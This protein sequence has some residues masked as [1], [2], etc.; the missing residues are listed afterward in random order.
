MA[1]SGITTFLWF[2]GL[3]KE[4]AEFYVSLFPGAEM[5]D[6]SY[7]QRDAQ[8]PEGDVLTAAFTLFGRPYVCLLYTSPSPRD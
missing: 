2:D 1:L 8:R 5:G 6:V 3:A 4:A 7:Y